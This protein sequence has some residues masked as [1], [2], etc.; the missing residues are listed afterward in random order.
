MYKYDGMEDKRTRKVL[1]DKRFKPD[2]HLRLIKKTPPSG[3]KTGSL[4]EI[5][6][7]PGLSLFT[8]FLHLQ[9]IRS[10]MFHQNN[11]KHSC[12]QVTS[13]PNGKPKIVAK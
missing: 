9:R 5:K 2:F 3:K 7:F 11:D 13:H 6:I 1:I 4:V 8:L 10:D 12:K